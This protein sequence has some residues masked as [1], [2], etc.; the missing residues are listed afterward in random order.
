MKR[1]LLFFFFSGIFGISL[2]SQYVSIEGR[3][4]KDENGNDFY[5]VVCNYIV[6]VVNTNPN[7]FSTTYISP[8]HSWGTGY[9]YECN[10]CTSCDQQLINDFQQIISMGFNTIR[11]MGIQ[12]VY[13][14]AGYEIPLNNW[15]CPTSGF[16]CQTNNISLQNG[17]DNT[18]FYLEPPYTGSISALLFEHTAHLV[19]LVSQTSYEGKKLKVILVTGGARGDYQPEFPY[20]YAQ[21]LEAYANGLL[22]HLPESKQST[23]L[24]YDLFNEPKSSWNSWTLWPSHQQYH[25]KEDVCNNVKLWYNALKSHDPNHLI[26]LGGHGMA[27]LFEF[28]PTV[29]KL[30]FYSLHVYPFKREYESSNYL[31]PM[32]D[33][34]HGYIYWCQN[35]IS[36]PWIIG[37]TGFRAQD[38]S[39]FP[40][41]D[42]T[43]TDQ[44]N[45][46]ASTL[47]LSCGCYGSGYS[48]W[49]YQNFYWSENQNY[50]GILDYGN[51]GVPCNALEKPVS[52]AFEEF[53]PPSGT[54]MCSEPPNYR[55][56]YQHKEYFGD[57]IIFKGWVYDQDSIPITDALVQG[58]TRLY[59]VDNNANK[60]I[61]NTHYTFTDTS[62][63]FE[64]RPFDYDTASPNYFTIEYL[65]ISAAG[66]SRIY[67]ACVFPDIGLPSDIQYYLSRSTIS[68]EVVFEDITIA[69]NTQQIIEA[70]HSITLEDI[71]VEP[72][73]YLEA[74]AGSEI[75]INQEFHAQTN[76]EA[77]I[78][79]DMPCGAAGDQLETDHPIRNQEGN[80]TEFAMREIDLQFE[81]APADFNVEV[82]PNPNTGTFQVM[83][84]ESTPSAFYTL[85]LFDQVAGNILTV[86]KTESDFSLDLTYLK[87]GVYYLRISTNV[88][89][90]TVK[91]ILF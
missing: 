33:R 24:A 69:S 68:T 86:R 43:L 29:M 32:L 15:T 40:R 21:Y 35:H 3:Q 47:S 16:Y 25:T 85:N 46:A 62:G 59:N 89:S 78:Y 80:N 83:I 61:W 91:I 87:K 5:P 48:W 51:C 63:Y 13:Y 55:D 12:S 56:P 42:G 57:S 81:V 49:T 27:D 30:D 38:T 34:I 73:G 36:I 79:T 31:D 77:W 50:F 84:T 75:T 72:G 44:Y 1:L 90:K 76:S 20:V 64:L 17:S 39:T 4:F 52:Q 14:P 54:S 9:S 58:W 28:D 6:D 22:A 2:F 60:P 45:Y 88:Q 23:I 26:T 18:L 74:S 82:F 11:I 71:I 67:R 37:E 66:A 7:D 41:L 53:E 19:E 10:N 65:K 8:E 70:W